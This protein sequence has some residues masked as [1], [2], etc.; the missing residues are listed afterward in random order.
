MQVVIQ[1]NAAY[2]L[3]VSSIYEE[4]ASAQL[5]DTCY[6][7]YQK[8]VVLGELLYAMIVPFSYT[9]L[10]FPSADLRWLRGEPMA[11]PKQERNE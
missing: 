3:L 11:L 10:F 8:G 2:L 9:E 5:R 6:D 7:A 4:S 1:R